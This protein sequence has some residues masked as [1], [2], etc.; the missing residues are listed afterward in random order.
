MQ[1]FFED[2]HLLIVNKPAGVL[3][4]PS[5]TLQ[6]S[7]EA[8][9]KQWVKE[10][11]NKPGA[12][13]LETVHRL[14]KPVSGIVLFARTSKAL[15]RL[16]ESM[17]GK[18]FLK[19]YCALVEGQ[20][21]PKEGILTNYLIHDDF[22][23][24]IVSAQTPG[25]KICTLKYRTL[26]NSDG[27]SLIEIVLETGRYHQIRAQLSAAKYPVV[28]D[29]KYGSL[30]ILGQNIIALHHG[31]PT[32]NNKGNLEVRKSASFLFQAV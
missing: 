13:F 14:D 17:R 22:H 9:C 31:I 6:D 32:P 29:T 19:K 2:N 25:A 26:K 30:K 20:I 5:G 24:T 23:A 15:T 8:Q 18:L 16:N 12:V 1:I 21:V 10:K 11:L 3:T 27:L 7:L 4:Q 28:G